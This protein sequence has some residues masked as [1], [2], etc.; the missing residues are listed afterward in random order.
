MNY[1]W[2]SSYLLNLITIKLLT[3]QK[4]Q[5]FSLK[6]ILT[7]LLHMHTVMDFRLDTTAMMQSKVGIF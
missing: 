6:G 4:A 1:I 5:N 7:I 3:I 2:V